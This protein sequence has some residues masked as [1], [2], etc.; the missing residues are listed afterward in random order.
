MIQARL[1]GLVKDED[2]T[3]EL[4]R[5]SKRL[6]R[7]EM[8][9]ELCESYTCRNE[10]CCRWYV[11]GED[12]NVL[13][14]WLRME[15][16]LPCTFSSLPLEVSSYILG[17]LTD[18][19][20]FTSFL[21]VSRSVLRLVVAEV[22]LR[23][24]FW[25]GVEF[26]KDDYFSSTFR[27]VLQA[28]IARSSFTLY[29]HLCSVCNAASPFV[30]SYHPFMLNS[31]FSYKENMLHTFNID[32]YSMLIEELSMVRFFFFF[33]LTFYSLNRRDNLSRYT[34]ASA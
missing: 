3:T 5:I 4:G 9:S 16:N 30:Y 15:M 12:I 25:F 22:N 7:T 27:D 10:T 8:R 11:L 24:K 13:N 31:Y 6:N 17:Q 26:D 1:T 28:Y 21:S 23:Y 34:S 20:V 32:T 33:L 18:R 2:P 14:Y 19:F 29:Q